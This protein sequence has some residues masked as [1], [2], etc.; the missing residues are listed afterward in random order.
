MTTLATDQPVCVTGASGFVASQIVKDLLERG[1]R[2]RGTVRRPP[3]TGSYDFLTQL[4]GAQERLQL[5]Q[6]NLLEPETFEAAVEGCEVVMHTASPYQLTVEDP[7]KDLV[8][9]AVKGTRGVLEA[10]K[11]IGGAR[12]VVLTS[13]MAA[14]TDEPDSNQVLTEDDWN[15]KSS[16]ERNPYYY[17]KTLAERAAW[18]FVKNEG[19][20][21]DLVVVNPFLVIGPS[22]TESLNTSNKVFLD[23]LNGR[24]PALV[25]VAWGLVDVR[26]VAA[27]HRLAME[28]QTA[29]GR[30][31]CANVT[32]KMREVVDRFKDLGY[33]E[34]KLPKLGLDNGFGSWLVLATSFVQP[35]GTRSY[36]KTNLGRVPRF[37]NGKI[38]SDLG[39]EFRP[40]DETLKDMVED[41]RRWGHL[42]GEA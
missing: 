30:Y 8:D 4:E 27:A 41:L 15:E 20:D 39:L 11:K 32:L 37:D 22:L 5:F 36:L 2:V 29:S 14:V 28:V 1:Y 21:F 33:G 31:L 38:R 16:L 40:I 6:A 25:E 26:D 19:V 12:R 3:H 7:Q 18:E 13:S 34:Y 17:S 23:L 24:T 42:K 9:P 10:V 35:K